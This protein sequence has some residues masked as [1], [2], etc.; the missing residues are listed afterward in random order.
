MDKIKLSLPVIVEGKYDKIK[1]LSVADATVITTDGFGVFNNTEKRAVI[2]RLSENGVILLCDSDGAGKLIRSHLSGLI[3]PEKTY[4]LY[5]PQIKGKEKRKAKASA[6]GLLGVEG[7]SSDI[8]RE[9]I[10]ALIAIHPEVVGEAKSESDVIT[11][12][13][14]YFAGLSGGENS[15]EKR[16]RL[17]SELSLPAGMSA[18]ALLSALNM[19]ITKEVFNSICGKLEF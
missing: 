19:I 14:L 11:K 5:V 9:R 1:I 2:R 8:L 18:P 12:T 15:S 3:P 4:Q 10:M 13:D 16:D 17:A 6:E 7:I